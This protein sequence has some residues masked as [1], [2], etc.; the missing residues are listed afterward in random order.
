MKGWVAAAAGASLLAIAVVIYAPAGLVDGRVA[1]ATDGRIRIAGATGTV[2][3]GAGDLVL[4]PRGTRRP[5]A[6]HIDAWPL[7]AG[8]TRGTLALDSN[9]AQR[10]AFDFGHGRAVVRGLDA[11]L[12]ME[13]LLQTAG[14]PAAFS[15][16]GGSVVAHV[17]RFVRTADTLDAEL[18]L[19]WKDASLPAPAPGLRI[20][21]GDIDVELR[22]SGPQIGGAVSN[23]GG[24]VEIAGRVSVDAALNPKLDATLRPRPGIDR[25]RADAIATALSLI[26]IPDGQGGYRLSWSR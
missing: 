21:L 18:S 16:A 5:L 3:N 2:W 19:Q 15:A 17:E 4:L 10:A 25:D 12:P 14:V 24:D 6:W 7:L 1:A 11:D 26:G 23:R 20:A 22:G 13:A 8:E 9:A